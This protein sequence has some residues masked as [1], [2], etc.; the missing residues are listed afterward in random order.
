MVELDGLG[1]AAHFGLAQVRVLLLN[2]RREGVLDLLDVNYA[3][4]VGDPRA[5]TERMGEFLG[6]AF[7]VAA[8]GAVDERLRHERQ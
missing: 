2:P 3:D 7:D 8:P 4:A 6:G 1:A 5:V